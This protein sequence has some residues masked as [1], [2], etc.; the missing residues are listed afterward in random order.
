MRHGADAEQAE[1]V[2]QRQ[3]VFAPVQSV[4]G[5]AELDG[6]VSG[7]LADEVA[8]QVEVAVELAVDRQQVAQLAV[9]DAHIG[10]DQLPWRSFVRHGFGEE[11]EHHVGIVEDASASSANR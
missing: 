3:E 11:V 10:V 2:Q 6:A 4:Q 5:E 8:Q 9:V 7:L 1:V